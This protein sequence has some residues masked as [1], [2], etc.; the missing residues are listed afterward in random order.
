ME[1]FTVFVKNKPGQLARVC[2]VLAQS[3]VNIEAV[4]TEGAMEDGTVKIITSDA[5][6]ARKALERVRIQFEVKDVIVVGVMN[7]PG[8]LAK[9]TQKIGNV[10]VNI[11]S[12]S[13]LGTG[14]YAVRVADSGKVRQALKE[15]LVG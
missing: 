7:R 2:S 15:D 4:A 11:E 12:I 3:A 10:G 9:V 5:T 1:E 13:K 6:T 8:E 14:R